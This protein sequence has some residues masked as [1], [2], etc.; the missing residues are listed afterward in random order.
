M[1]VCL[2]SRLYLFHASHSFLYRC[3][4]FN[5]RHVVGRNQP[6]ST[7]NFASY[8]MLFACRQTRI[9]LRFVPIQHCGIILPHSPASVR[10]EHGA[11]KE[12]DCE[13]VPGKYESIAPHETFDV[14]LKAVHDEAGNVWGQEKA[15]NVEE[16]LWEGGGSTLHF[17][18]NGAHYNSVASWHESRS[19]EKGQP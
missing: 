13:G 9:W 6:I 7:I 15:C 8:S 2:C 16:Y 18:W 10:K 19:K 11:A 3:L 1:I 14:V 4:Y 12:Q 17:L 5:S